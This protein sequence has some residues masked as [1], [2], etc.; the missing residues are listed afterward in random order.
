MIHF[1]FSGVMANIGIVISQRGVD[2][3]RLGR[4]M[5]IQS[6]SYIHVVSG[7]LAYDMSVSTR[8]VACIALVFLNHPRYLYSTRAE[9]LLCS[10]RHS[11]TRY[12]RLLHANQISVDISYHSRYLSVVALSFVRCEIVPSRR[13][14]KYVIHRFLSVL[15][16]TTRGPVSN[17]R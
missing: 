6:R 13:Y 14:L 8:Y 1:A 3:T 15:F 17:D 4:G 9:R 10:A 5:Q 11:M 12:R 7:G 2:E 16:R